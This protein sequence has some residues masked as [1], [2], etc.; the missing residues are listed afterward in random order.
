M[1]RLRL[2]MRIY[3]FEIHELLQVWISIVKKL[4]SLTRTV[5]RAVD[6]TTVTITK[7]YLLKTVVCKKQPQ[8]I[9][10]KFE[11]KSNMCIINLV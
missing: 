11:Y 4:N 8:N 7:R 2:H 9:V 1:L 3:T 6:T 10:L 5:F